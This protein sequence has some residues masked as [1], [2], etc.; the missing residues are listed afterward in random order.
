M[1]ERLGRRTLGITYVNVDTLEVL[2]IPVPDSSGRPVPEPELV[3]L[4]RRLEALAARGRA[5]RIP[6]GAPP[7]PGQPLRVSS[8]P[9]PTPTQPGA[10][11]L[12]PAPGHQP[13]APHPRQPATRPAEPRQ[14]IALVQVTDLGR[15]CQDRGRGR[16]GVGDRREDG[17]PRRRRAGGAAR[18][19]REGARPRA[20]PIRSALARL[21]GH[22]A[23][24]A[25]HEPERRAAIGRPANFDGYVEVRLGDRPRA[26]RRST[27]TTPISR[28]G[29]STSLRL[30]RRAAARWRPRSSPSAASTGRA[31]RCSPRRSFAPVCS[32]RSNAPARTDS[33]KCIFKDRDDGVLRERTLGA[34]RL[35]HPAALGAAP[36]RSAARATTGSA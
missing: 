1:V 17:R 14:P 5:G 16:R 34:L 32:A 29:A 28:P 33:V 23:S 26:G 35:R 11:T 19:R 6:L 21:R 18:R 31:T 4:G 2:T 24:A 7:R 36:R 20:S 25:A 3:R 30:G 10:P 27:S 12:V 8:F 22:P 15:P 9:R 13:A